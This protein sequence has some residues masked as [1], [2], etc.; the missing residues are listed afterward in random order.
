MSED[1]QETLLL[2]EEDKP[3]LLEQ[4]CEE[5]K[6]VIKEFVECYVQNENRPVEEWLTPK[7][8]E[9][10]PDRKK[11]EIQLMVEEIVSTIKN[12]EE[13]QESLSKAVNMGRSKE[14]WLASEL[15][16][17]T[18]SMSAKESVQYLKELDSS[19][20]KA[21][22]S[23]N[24]TITTQSGNVNQNPCLDGYIA[25]QYHAQ[26]FNLN[27]QAKG[28]EYRAKVL[29]PEG[30]AYA[31]NSVDIVIVDGNDKVVKRYQSKYCKDAKATERAFEQGDYRGQQKLVPE[32]QQS[33]IIKKSTTVIEAPDGTTSKPFNSVVIN[34]I[35]E[36][37]LSESEIN[38]LLEKFDE[39]KPSRF[40]KLF[41]DVMSADRQEKQIEDFIRQ[42]F[43]VIIR[44]RPRIS[45]P[46]PKDFVDF[47]EQL[48]LQS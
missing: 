18:S 25:E 6:P 33:K 12:N 26:T 27:A 23:L 14:S 45:E 2:D 20:E 36:Y 30:K 28:S 11:E 37:M 10:L 31:K 5:L 32:D 39:I 44:Q 13:K 46:K 43:E 7:L 17:A 42:Y 38:V 3:I 41:A 1:I 4:E 24:R 47:F 21:N 19:L 29:E 35:Y 34:M 15:K 40:K 9:Q 8:Q 22:I 48:T 16:K